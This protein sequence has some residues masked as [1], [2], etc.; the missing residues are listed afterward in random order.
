MLQASGGADQSGIPAKGLTSQTYDGHYFWD[1]EMYVLPFLIYTSPR[2]ARNVCSIGTA[3]WT[4]P[5]RARAVSQKGALF[6]WR[7]ISGEEASAYYAAGTAQY[8]INAAI[9]YGIVKYVD[10]TGDRTFCTSAGRRSSSR[11]PGCGTTWASSRSARTDVSASTGSPG[12]TNTPRWST[13]T[14]TR[15]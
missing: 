9:A 4:A 2:L 15:T 13:T 10:V 8:H 7:T 5:E 1:M 11:P 12:R 3:S 14:R 6:A